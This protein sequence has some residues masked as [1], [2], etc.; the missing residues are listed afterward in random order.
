MHKAVMFPILVAL[1]ACAGCGSETRAQSGATVQQTYQ[2]DG[3]ERIAVAGPYD[4]R[5]TTGGS[6]SVSATGPKNVMENLIVEVKGDHLVIHAR[7]DR[8]MFN[9]SRGSGGK[10]VIE[11][12]APQLRAASLAGSGR[13]AVDRVTGDEF[14]GSI[15]GSGDM[16]I[17]ALD[18]QTVKLSIAGSG[19]LSVASGQAQNAEYR[20]AGS[21][22]VDS[23]GVR[24]ETAKI[25]IAGSGSVSSQATGTADVNIIGSGDVVLTGG[26]R[27][28]VKQTGSGN[29]RCS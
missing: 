11:V 14:T 29:V 13:I 10:A 16:N 3:F 24:S 22:D 21:G 12:S 7:S 1:A 9:W 15:A 5:V 27:C 19:D 18:V 26:A 17:Q 4:V 25:T 8:R 2:V 28:N 23:S 6:A 20:I